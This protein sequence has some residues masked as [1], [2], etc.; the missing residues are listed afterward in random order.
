MVYPFF[1]LNCVSLQTRLFGGPSSLK[2]ST[3]INLITALKATTLQR[4]FVI[5]M[6]KQ[7][8]VLGHKYVLWRTSLVQSCNVSPPPRVFS[9]LY[10]FCSK[11]FPRLFVTKKTLNRK[12][13]CITLSL[14]PITFQWDTSRKA[15]SFSSE[16]RKI[17]WVK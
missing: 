4:V 1:E 8:I 16:I 14:V 17:L 15:S 2:T 5:N 11:M 13:Y 7:L 3:T 6:Y 10:P 9:I 12:T